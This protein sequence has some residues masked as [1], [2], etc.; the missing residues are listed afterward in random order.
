MV[1]YVSPPC[2]F[3]VV[4]KQ[5]CP[6]TVSAYKL[7]LGQ[8]LVFFRTSEK[9]DIFVLYC[10]GLTVMGSDEVGGSDTNGDTPSTSSFYVGFI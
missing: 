7:I 5:C 6:Q 9:K 3:F 10:I 2:P 1:N 4:V 8:Y